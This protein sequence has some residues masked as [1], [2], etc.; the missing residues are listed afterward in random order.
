MAETV[1]VQGTIG[2]CLE[3][4]KTYAE[5]YGVTYLVYF[6]GRLQK[7]VNP[8]GDSCREIP[9]YLNWRYEYN[10]YDNSG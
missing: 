10:E 4:L 2:R 1:K 6:S 3:N 8:I 5:K 9:V 7:K